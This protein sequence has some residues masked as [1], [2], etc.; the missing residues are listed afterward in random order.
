MEAGPCHLSSAAC[1]R[2]VSCSAKFW[3]I[4]AMNSGSHLRA[5]CCFTELQDGLGLKRP[6]R[7][8]SFKGGIF[9]WFPLP[10]P[11]SPQR[12]LGP[13]TFRLCS[14]SGPLSLSDLLFSAVLRS[15]A[16][17]RMDTGIISRIKQG[18][19]TGPEPMPTRTCKNFSEKISKRGKIVS[20]AQIKLMQKKKKSESKGCI[21]KAFSQ[22]PLSPRLEAAGRVVSCMVLILSRADQVSGTFTDLGHFR[23]PLY[24]IW[25][26]V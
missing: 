6:Q 16:C 10:R 14:L 2:C 20:G 21:R 4:R 8:S 24:K 22:V 1:S 12:D 15:S 3:M 7:S 18:F 9:Y 5:Q 25:E 11:G 26:P 17:R 19:L 13:L 23:I